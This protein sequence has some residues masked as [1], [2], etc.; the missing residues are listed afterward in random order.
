M[1]SMSNAHNAPVRIGEAELYANSLREI[2]RELGK[3]HGE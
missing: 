2:E 1:K 3:L